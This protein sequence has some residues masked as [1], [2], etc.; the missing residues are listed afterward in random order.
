MS[1]R[2]C[3]VVASRGGRPAPPGSMRA[4]SSVAIDSGARRPCPRVVG[5]HDVE[6][7]AAHPPRGG[8]D[9][10]RFPSRVH[11]GLRPGVVVQPEATRCGG[12]PAGVDFGARSACFISPRLASREWPPCCSA[13]GPR[14]PTSVSP[15][16]GGTAPQQS[17][18]LAPAD[19]QLGHE[20]V[21]VALLLD[22]DVLD[23]GAARAV[24]TSPR[25]PGAG[26]RECLAGSLLERDVHEARRDD[27]ARFDPLTPSRHEHARRPLTTRRARPPG[28]RP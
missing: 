24:G 20:P 19:E 5:L 16:E 11:E 22:R 21:A 26:R 25:D 10:H 6:E 2:R 18:A 23:D 4:R 13:D 8:D 12:R 14:P 27:R 17:S 28:A 9:R 15:R 3:D 1:H 7:T